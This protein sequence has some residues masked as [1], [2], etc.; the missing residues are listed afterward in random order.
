MVSGKYVSKFSEASHVLF[1]GHLNDPA[2]RSI[3]IQR[4]TKLAGETVTLDKAGALKIE[5]RN[6]EQIVKTSFVCPLFGKRTTI[7]HPFKDER[8]DAV[9]NVTGET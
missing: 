2:F 5:T 7:G 9:C 1:E 3:A 6:G 4:I 8:T